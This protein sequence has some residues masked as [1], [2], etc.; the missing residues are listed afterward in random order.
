MYDLFE[1]WLEC[2]NKLKE[3][4]HESIYNVWI[5]PIMP[6]ELTDTYLKVAVNSSVFSKMLENKYASKIENTLEE[7]LGKKIHLIIESLENKETPNPSSVEKKELPTV[8]VK[9]Q[10]V[11]QPKEVNVSP[12]DLFSMFGQYLSVP[13][14]FT[15]STRGI[16]GLSSL[17]F[18]D[19]LL[20]FSV[21]LSVTIH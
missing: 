6:L 19:V 7:I 3:S 15:K 13:C 14:S 5:E 17:S 2:T 4:I 18:S 16:G 12:V 21:S 11:T 20:A 9:K 1:V 8:T 10:E